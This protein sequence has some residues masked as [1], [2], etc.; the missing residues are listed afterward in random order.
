MKNLVK[1]LIETNGIRSTPAIYISILLAHLEMEHWDEAKYIVK[2][3]QDLDMKQEETD[4]Y[5]Y[6]K[7]IVSAHDKEALEDLWAYLN[8]QK[9]DSMSKNDIIET[10]T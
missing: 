4:A 3:M 6:L 5:F 8:V 1:L 2:I 7:Q 10:K 9:V